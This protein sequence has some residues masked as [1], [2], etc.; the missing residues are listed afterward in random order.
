MTLVA[1]LALKPDAH[2]LNQ[3]MNWFEHVANDHGWPPHTAFALRLCMDEAL[4]N[5]LMHG[6]AQGVDDSSVIELRISTDYP[7]IMLEILDNGTPFDPTSVVPAEPAAKLADAVPGGH[8]TRIMRHYLED[9]QYAYTD[10]RNH[11]LLTAR[12]AGG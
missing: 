8:G 9:I 5:T 2:A 11:L 12:Q 3:A 6:F 7:L 4:T 1:T 10:G